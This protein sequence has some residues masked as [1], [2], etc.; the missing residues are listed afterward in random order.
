MQGEAGAFK[1]G[2][3]AKSDK[4][5]EACVYPEIT[6]LYQLFLRGLEI[7][8]NNRCLGQRAGKN[9]PYHFISYAETYRCAQ[10]LGS[11]FVYKLGAKPGKLAKADLKHV[12]FRKRN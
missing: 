9:Q 12:I 4:E 8:E 3:L 6:T 10:N 5:Y 7:S 1:S 2:L 11:A